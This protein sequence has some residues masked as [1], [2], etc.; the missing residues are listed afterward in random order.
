MLDNT[1]LK[2]KLKDKELYLIEDAL[3]FLRD[4]RYGDRKSDN[5]LKYVEID[6]LIMKLK[7]ETK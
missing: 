4:V 5:L 1:A 3:I 7:E 2:G 6:N